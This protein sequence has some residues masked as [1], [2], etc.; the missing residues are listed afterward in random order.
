MN[1]IINAISDYTTSL[2]ENRDN[3]IVGSITAPVDK[4]DEVYDRYLE[5]YMEEGG[6]QVAEEK[7]AAVQ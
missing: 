3:L 6:A 2:E 4:F 7:L 5:I 1:R